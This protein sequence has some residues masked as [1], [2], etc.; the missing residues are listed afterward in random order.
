MYQS[1]ALDISGKLAD[2]EVGLGN[3]SL[4]SCQITSTRKSRVFALFSYKLSG[5]IYIFVKQSAFYYFTV[6]KQNTLYLKSIVD[7]WWKAVIFRQH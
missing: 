4:N 5:Y 2:Y 6:Y 3:L 1:A 7:Q